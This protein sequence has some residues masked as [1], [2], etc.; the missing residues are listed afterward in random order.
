MKSSQ[1]LTGGI[2]MLL[3]THPVKKPEEEK[4]EPSRKKRKRKKIN[5]TDKQLLKESL[6]DTFNSIKTLK[7]TQVGTKGLL[8][9]WLL[10]WQIFHTL[11]EQE[12][13]FTG[14]NPLIS[15]YFCWCAVPSSCFQTHIGMIPR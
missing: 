15:L 6:F 12:R 4:Q 8:L 9:C 5:G 2:G 10:L 11:V 1:R 14:N 13:K 7:N 3:H